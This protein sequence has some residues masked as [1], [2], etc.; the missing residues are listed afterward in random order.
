MTQNDNDAR[1][2]KKFQQELDS[3]NAVRRSSLDESGKLATVTKEYSEEQ[4]SIP[5]KS[6][7]GAAFSKQPAKETVAMVKSEPHELNTTPSNHIQPAEPSEQQY[8]TSNQMMDF[9]QY[10][11]YEEEYDIQY[12]EENYDSSVQQLQE[13]SAGM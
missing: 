7:Q 12:S 13:I 8:S 5:S 1:H 9:D 3:S 11:G 2:S 10:Q 4:I 6:T